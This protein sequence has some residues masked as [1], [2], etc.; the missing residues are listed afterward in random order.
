MYVARGWQGHATGRY[1]RVFRSDGLYKDLQRGRKRGVLLG[2]SAYRLEQFLL[3]PYL[4]DGRTEAQVRFTE[5]LKKGRVCVERAFGAQ[6]RQ[7][8]A[9]HTELQSVLAAT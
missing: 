2:D 8:L 4:G 7:F 5:A 9:L 6:K 1:L 3:K